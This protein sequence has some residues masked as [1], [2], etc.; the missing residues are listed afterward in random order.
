MDEQ[1]D[2]RRISPTEVS[3]GITVLAYE[4]S[5]TITGVLEGLEAVVERLPAMRSEVLVADDHSTDGTAK[6]VSGWMASAG[7]NLDVEIVRHDRNLGYGGNQKSVVRW[8][9][10]RDLDLLV[11]MHGD[12]QHDPREIPA[13][14]GPLLADDAD[15]VLGRERWSRE[16][17]GMGAC[18]CTDSSATAA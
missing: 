7:T 18:P 8:A 17:R 13:L 14:I 15:V 12:G 11:V 9:T 5:T 2:D 10:A 4:A 6:L 16:Q 1:D 3:V